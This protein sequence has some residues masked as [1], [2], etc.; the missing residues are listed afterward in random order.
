[1]DGCSLLTTAAVA[2][3]GSST[4]LYQS[5]MLSGG[6]LPWIIMLS[7]FAFILA[8]NFIEKF[9]ATTLTMM[10]IASQL[11]WVCR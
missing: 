1:M 5:L 2:W 10:F 9:S 11:V 7:P 3:Y 6:I 8:M 4:G